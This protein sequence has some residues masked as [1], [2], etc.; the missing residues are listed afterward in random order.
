MRNARIATERRTAVMPSGIMRGAKDTGR[1]GCRSIAGGAPQAPAVLDRLFNRRGLGIETENKLSTGSW[2]CS[3]PQGGHAIVRPISSLSQGHYQSAGQT[4]EESRS[5]GAGSASTPPA[6][7]LRGPESPT[8]AERL[9]LAVRLPYAIGC[10]LVGFFLFGLLDVVFTKHAQTSNLSTALAAALT[11]SSLLTDLLV[12]YAFYAPRFMRRKLL[13]AGRA[14]SPLLPDR[15]SEFQRIFS[16]VAAPRP[17]SSLGSC[18]S[19]PYSSLSTPRRSSAR[20]RLRSCSTLAPV[21]ASS[22]RRPFTASSRWPWRR[23]RS[24]PSSGRSGASPWASIVSEALRSRCART[25]RTH[26]SG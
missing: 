2:A 4:L 19:S 16:E 10:L 12:A 11:P 6:G 1:S 3:T 22:S 21:P 14:L 7:A 23:W 25:T 15:E 13:D 26:S 9:I 17:H 5:S 24:R 18:S 8:L 20:A